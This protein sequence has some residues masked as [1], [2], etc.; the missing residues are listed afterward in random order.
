ME[1]KAA[2]R[3]RA[4]QYDVACDGH[5]CTCKA[6]IKLSV[7]YLPKDLPDGADQLED[8]CTTGGVESGTARDYAESVRVNG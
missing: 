1:E 2:V 4:D 3:F 8:R 5:S 6:T 7:P